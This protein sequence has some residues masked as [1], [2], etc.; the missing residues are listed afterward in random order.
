M[1][2]LLTEQKAR[3][4]LESGLDEINFSLTGVIP[5]VYQHFQGSGI[6]YEK[7]AAQL[8]RVIENIKRLA[9]M[10]DEMGAKTYIRLRYIRSD[11]S[12]AHLKDYVAFWK[13]TGVDE[14]FVTSLWSFKRNKKAKL[15]VLRC[16]SAPRRYQVSANGDVFPCTCNYDDKR[17][18]MGNIHETDF[19]EIITSEKFL[20]EKTNRM[21]CDLDV[22]P[23]SCLSC[24]N[25][26]LRALGE[27]LKHMRKIYFLKKPVKTFVYRLFGPAVVIFERISRYKIFYN[28]FLA[29]IRRTSAKIHDEFVARKNG[30]E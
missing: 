27:E 14:V 4:L 17:N 16:S 30:G 22:V 23:K 26:A 25:R 15:K 5:E 3:E 21:S 7:C 18:F 11:N 10:R 13:G 24:E 12:A 20:Q 19:K 9:K 6:P 2:L 29:H 8:E 28:M 1:A